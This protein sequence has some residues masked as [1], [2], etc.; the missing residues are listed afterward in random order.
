MINLTGQQRGRLR[1]ALL[2][3]FPTKASLEQLLLMSLNKNLDAIAG[4]NNLFS[5]GFY[6][7]LGYENFDNGSFFERAF[8]EG[9]LAVA[10]Q[11]PQEKE[12][13]VLEVKTKV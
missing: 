7:G 6:D 8:K 10:L 9:K 4:G 11:Y 5:E 2:N 3:A 1:D 13:L 12:T